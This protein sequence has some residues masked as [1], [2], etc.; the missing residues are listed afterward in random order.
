ML[1]T[2]I[3]AY[4]PG[5]ASGRAWRDVRSASR[6]RRY[7]IHQRLAHGSLQSLPTGI[8]A[9]LLRLPDWSPSPPRRFKILKAVRR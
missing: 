9:S 6:A 4:A 5:V 3:P 7:E 1:V 2:Y 8:F